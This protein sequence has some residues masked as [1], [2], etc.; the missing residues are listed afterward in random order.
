MN[1]KDIVSSI[2]KA[3]NRKLRLKSG[4]D[5]NGGMPEVHFQERDID[6]EVLKHKMKSPQAETARSSPN[7]ATIM[8]TVPDKVTSRKC[9]E[10]AI[11]NRRLAK[12]QEVID[13]EW[14]YIDPSR[15]QSQSMYIN[16][17]HFSEDSLGKSDDMET[18]PHSLSTLS[19]HYSMSGDMLNKL[20]KIE[21]AA[22]AL[23]QTEEKRM[24]DYERRKKEKHKLEQDIQ[25]TQK[26]IEFEDSQNV[27]DIL[28]APGHPWHSSSDLP[29][30]SP[31]SKDSTSDY[32]STSSGASSR[33]RHGG[34]FSPTSNSPVWDR[35]KRREPKSG[36]KFFVVQSSSKVPLAKR[37]NSLEAMLEEGGLNTFQQEAAIKSSSKRRDDKPP[38]W[39]L[40]D[41]R[42]NIR[43]SRGSLSRSNSVRHGS[44]DS[45]IDMIDKNEITMSNA[46][47]DSEDGS[48][49]L[50]DLTSTFDQK[51]QVLVNPKYKL[52]GAGI[53]LNKS[54]NSNPSCKPVL[55]P[56]PDHIVPTPDHSAHARLPPQLPLS[57]VNKHG[58]SSSN[59]F[60]EKEYRDPSLHRSPSQKPEAIVGIAYRFERNPSNTA[61]SPVSSRDNLGAQATSTPLASSDPRTSYMAVNPSPIASMDSRPS[62]HLMSPRLYLIQPSHVFTPPDSTNLSKSEKTEVNASLKKERPKTWV[63]SDFKAA[64]LLPEPVKK[65]SEK[66]KKPR[67]HTIGGSSE[68]HLRALDS[69][70]DSKD[71]SRL[72]AWERLQPAVKD[73]Q[74]SASRSMLSWL[75]NERLRGSVPDLSDSSNKYS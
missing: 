66:R 61:M 48:D 74:S 29:Q 54:D 9:S 7:I 1:P 58:L 30:Y 52:T 62:T 53:R 60:L 23:R 19:P 17:R 69:L 64:L 57:Q 56:P 46:S 22:R 18:S 75:Q 33:Y 15:T 41:S 73:G 3:A 26:E 4:D 43:R 49:L 45:L 8:S 38:R 14:G 6:K 25:R 21:E 16:T 2:V 11:D 71:V 68:E 70:G 51:L 5:I 67:R 12:S 34:D 42:E 50:S 24:R 72:S 37:T 63:E 47:S 13:G 31:H 10:S 28:N 39:A 20:K 59:D 44:L 55:V 27:E 35:T 40:R 36:G 65:R 32:S